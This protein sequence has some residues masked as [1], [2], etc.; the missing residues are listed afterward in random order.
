MNQTP[1]PLLPAHGGNLAWA[2]QFFGIPE[3]GWL[4]LSTG[5]N[6]IPYSDIG[7]SS[8]ALTRLPSSAALD[9]LL[10]AARKAYDMPTQVALC[11]APGTQ[12]LIQLLPMLHPAQLVAVLSPTYSEHAGCWRAA[13][14]TII[15][16][17]DPGDAPEADVMV[18]TNPNN[19][20]G[21]R[22]RPD[23]LHTV[24]DRL[25]SR[26]GLLVIDEAF[27]DVAP[28]VSLAST[29]DQPGM[30]VLRSFGKFFGLAGLRLGFA[31][32]P[33]ALVQRIEIL[34]GPWAVSGPALEIGTRA[35][36]D[37]AWIAKTRADLAAYR[38]RLDK[39]LENAGIKLLGGTDLFR[40]TSHDAA[41]SIYR[42]L[43]HA[44]ILV[45]AFSGQPNWLR[46]GLPGDDAAFVRLERALAK[47]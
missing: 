43:G 3:E 33:P 18:I 8:D 41:Q 10:D 25:A 39:I 34:L 28:E 24:R 6:P 31:A 14:S 42:S 32:G 16:I 38:A 9:G 36:A 27:A 15:D 19:P 5:I 12:A 1:L 30:L 40:L 11:P 20:D 21:R 17:N 23:V 37:A 44:G 2:E 13:G 22:F 47:M 46:F 29:A 35:L 45:R 7:V 4:D 26:G